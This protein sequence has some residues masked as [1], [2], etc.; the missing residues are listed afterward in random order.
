MIDSNKVCGLGVLWFLVLKR[1]K[2][3]KFMVEK[4]EIRSIYRERR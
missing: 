3:Y 1:G 4:Y 2:R